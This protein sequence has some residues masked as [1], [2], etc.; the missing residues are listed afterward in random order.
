MQVFVQFKDATEAVV[1][2][3]FGCP[4]DPAVYPN[5]GEIADDDPRYVAFVAT[6]P[7]PTF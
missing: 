7:Q 2:A 6:L 5:A 1:I 4:Q 3:A